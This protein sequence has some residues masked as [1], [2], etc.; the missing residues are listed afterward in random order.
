MRSPL[1]VARQQLLPGDV[2]AEQRAR[3]AERAR[4]APVKLLISP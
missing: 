1:N 2:R 3:A 4:V